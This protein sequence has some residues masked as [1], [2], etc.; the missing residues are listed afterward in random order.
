MTHFCHVDLVYLY[1]QCDPDEMQVCVSFHR[2]IHCMQVG[3]SR[4][5]IMVNVGRK[6]STCI[7]ESPAQFENQIKTQVYKRRITHSTMYEKA[8]FC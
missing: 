4:S 3:K 7:R 6:T 5:M 1:K 8:P 2:G